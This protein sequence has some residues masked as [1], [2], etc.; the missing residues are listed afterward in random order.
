MKYKKYKVLKK[1]YTNQ[2]QVLAYPNSTIQCLEPNYA[3][4]LELNGFIEEIKD[5]EPFSIKK[6]SRNGRAIQLYR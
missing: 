1:I 5:N 6:T 3:E 2:G 4:W